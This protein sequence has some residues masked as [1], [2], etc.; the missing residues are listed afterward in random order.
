MKK[1]NDKYYSID[2]MKEKIAEIK[3]LHKK[4]TEK[5][6]LQEV[7]CGASWQLFTNGAIGKLQCRICKV[8]V[9]DG[10]TPKCQKK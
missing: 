10:G 1:I 8:I 5:Q 2:D 3:E 6:M 9:T 7:S 4:P